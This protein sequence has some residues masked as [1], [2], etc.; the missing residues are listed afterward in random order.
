MVKVG[1]WGRVCDPITYDHTGHIKR[2][3]M[4]KSLINVIDFF[5]KIHEKIW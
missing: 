2:K 3:Y 4:Y 5:K 1:N